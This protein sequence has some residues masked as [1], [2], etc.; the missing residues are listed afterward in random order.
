MTSESKKWDALKAEYL[1][2]VQKT[3]SSVRHPRSKEVLDDVRSH[4]DRRFAELG[5]EQQTWENFQAIITE[6]GPASDYAELIEAGAA[7][8]GRNIRRRYLLWLGLAVIVVAGAILLIT[9]MRNDKVGYIVTFEPVEPFAP[10]TAR[11]LLDAF[12]ENHPRDA[13]TRHFRTGV[14]GDRLQGHICV[15]TT[16]A[17]KAVV[18]MIDTSDKL[19]LVNVRYVTQEELERHYALG[20]PSLSDAL[21]ESSNRKLLDESTLGQLKSHE[22]F[23]AA[24]FTVERRYEA[25]SESEKKKMIQQ[26]MADAAGDDF[27]KM[28]RAIAALGNVAAKEALGVLMNI[29][30]KPKRG[31]RPRWM[32]VRASVES[33]RPKQ[34]RC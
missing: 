22:Q 29:A 24:W 3:L 20:Q 26:W 33:V 19:I 23:S 32:A 8:P 2:K 15:D 18:S 7:A 25:A 14:R 5:A 13:S 28:T 1:R 10:Q 31:N 9:A 30:Q 16:A 11:E 6:M 12:N 21:P 34:C 4:L 17:A 27:E